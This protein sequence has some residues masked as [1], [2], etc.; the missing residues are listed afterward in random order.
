MPR[1]F[2]SVGSNVRRRSSIKA[3][4]RALYACYGQL[5]LS[6]V[7]ETDSV[8]FDGKP[9]YNFVVGFDTED[10]PLSIVKKMKSIELLCGRQRDGNKNSPRTLDLDLLL[11]GNLQI[12]SDNLQLPR[13][14]I[15]KYAFV[16][17]PLAD[18]IPNQL[19]PG[20]KQT[21]RQLWRAYK[22]R[23]QPAAATM[24]DW[25][26]VLPIHLMEKTV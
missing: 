21:F 16:L 14:E 18:V 19:C 10:K 2:V 13:D 9:F 3:G 6:P 25:N 4:M 1:V 20:E 7:Y 15:F 5:I 12:E 23:Q 8:G 17:Q 11:Y 24:L 26:P 22:Q